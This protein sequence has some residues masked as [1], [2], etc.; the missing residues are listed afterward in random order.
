MFL[1]VNNAVVNLDNVSN[2]NLIKHRNRIAFNMNYNIEL[3]IDEKTKYISD[4]VYWDAKDDREY[5]DNLRRLQSDDFFICEFIKHPNGF[6]DGDLV[7]VFIA[8]KFSNDGKPLF[9]PLPTRYFVDVDKVE[10]ELEYSY[11]YSPYDT[12]IVAR[13]NAP[14]GFFNGDGDKHEGFIKNMIFRIVY[15]PG[16]TP[17]IGTKSDNSKESEKTSLSYEEVVRKYNL[18]DVKVVKKY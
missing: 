13:A 18:E 16:S 15:I 10:K 6:V 9:S 1:K 11:N 8:D 12:E 2:I 5:E 7:F 4:Y 17:V 3:R 14:L